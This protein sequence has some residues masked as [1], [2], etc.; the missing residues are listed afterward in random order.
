M[1]VGRVMTFGLADGTPRSLSVLH[2]KWIVFCRVISMFLENV[3]KGLGLYESNVLS[4]IFLST[5]IFRMA[6]RRAFGALDLLI[7]EA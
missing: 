7:L 5:V 6:D 4:A 3:A 2:V 1:T